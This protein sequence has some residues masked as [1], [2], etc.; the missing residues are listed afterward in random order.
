MF[1]DALV[2]SL[3]KPFVIHWPTH[4]PPHLSSIV[5]PASDPVYL[6]MLQTIWWCCRQFE[7]VTDNLKTVHLI[8]SLK[9]I[10]LTVVQVFPKAHLRP[11]FQV[12]FPPFA[13]SPGKFPSLREYKTARGVKQILQ[14]IVNKENWRNVTKYFNW[15]PSRKAEL[16][17][18]KSLIILSE[19]SMKIVANAA[20]YSQ[21]GKQKE[22][23]CD[24]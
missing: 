16:F 14:V 21:N 3:E 11:D 5:G 15:D 9:E 8:S 19:G 6:K 24:R 13:S 22:K 12:C 10:C 18:R 2:A 4:W 1:L 23:K 20:A 7:N 17:E